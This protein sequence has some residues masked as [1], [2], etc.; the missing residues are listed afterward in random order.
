M[1]RSPQRS[2]KV[3]AVADVIVTMGRSVG[4]IP[5]GVDYRDWR[6]GDPEGASLGEVRRV[7]DDISRRV[8]ELVGELVPV[9][10]AT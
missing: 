9:P 1:P 5:A 10:A 3:F 8:Q 6:T 4:S 7:R 2:R